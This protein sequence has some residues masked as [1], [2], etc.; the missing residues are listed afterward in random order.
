MI[1][2]AKHAN[3]KLDLIQTHVIFLHFGIKYCP[4]WSVIGPGGVFPS[5]TTPFPIGR[6]RQTVLCSQPLTP[7][8]SEIIS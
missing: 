4:N 3:Y 5:A 1:H 6:H 2:F 7:K 8:T